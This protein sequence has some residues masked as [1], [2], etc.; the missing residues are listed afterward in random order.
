MKFT[1]LRVGSTRSTFLR[2]KPDKTPKSNNYFRGDTV[3]MEVHE[4]RDDESTKVLIARE[5]E[6][7]LREFPDGEG[8]EADKASSGLEVVDN[9]GSKVDVQIKNKI[10]AT[11][12]R[13]RIKELVSPIMGLI[14]LKK[15]KFNLRKK[16]QA[17]EPPFAELEEEVDERAIEDEELLLN[18]QP[19]SS[20]EDESVSSTSVEINDGAVEI[21]LNHGVEVDLGRVESGADVDA[22]KDEQSLPRSSWISPFTLLLC[23]ESRTISDNIDNNIP[24]ITDAIGAQMSNEEVSTAIDTETKEPDVWIENVLPASSDQDARCVQADPLD[25]MFSD[26]NVASVVEKSVAS[27]SNASSLSAATEPSS[28]T[29]LDSIITEKKQLFDNSTNEDEIYDDKQLLAM[30]KIFNFM[31]G[32][33]TRKKSVVRE[34]PD[35]VIPREV[36]LR[37]DLIESEFKDLQK[38]EDRKLQTKCEGV[39]NVEHL[40]QPK[41]IP[42]GRT[43]SDTEVIM[44]SMTHDDEDVAEAYELVKPSSWHGTEHQF[45][46]SDDDNDSSSIVT[47]LSGIDEDGPFLEQSKCGLSDGLHETL[48]W[49]GE[50][51]FNACP[52]PN[53]RTKMNVL[54]TA[55]L[56]EEAAYVIRDLSRGKL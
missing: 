18:I 48:L 11:G 35:I 45:Q 44:L 52:E 16:T 40:F 31:S 10:N 32:R 39:R 7:S 43:V 25:V 54:D 37:D 2:K 41:D 53:D 22:P 14:K 17:K 29:S 24:S 51:V 13:G 3:H 33:V 12:M 50:K 56:G 49:C 5:D 38:I 30:N 8:N 23:D 55:R 6:P 26:E 36:M 21:E 20:T 1:S 47:H 42:F 19:P 27:N 15:P 34:E 46:D 28:P 9:I 4:G